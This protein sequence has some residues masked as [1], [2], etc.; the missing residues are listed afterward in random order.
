VRD[1]QIDIFIEVSPGE[2]RAALLDGDSRLCHLYLERA[3][4]PSRQG[5]IFLGRV[6]KVEKGMGAA[7]ID[8][9]SG[10]SAFLGRARTLHEG[11]ALVVQVVRDGWG[12]KVAGVVSRPQVEGRYLAIS[13]DHDDSSK[14]ECDRNIV[15]RSLRMQLEKSVEKFSVVGEK[16]RIRVAAINV[17][18]SELEFEVTQLRKRWHKIQ[19]SAATGSGP[20]VLEPTSSLALRLMRE[21]TKIN[22]IIV[23]DRSVYEDCVRLAA[24]EMP[25]LVGKIVHFRDVS[26]LFRDHGIDEQV[27]EA[28]ERNIKLPS[29]LS[30]TID[31]TEALTAIDVDMGGA[32]VRGRQEEECTRANLIAVPEIA[33]QMILRNLAGLIVIDFISMRNKPNRRRVVDAMRK[34]LHASSDSVVDVLGMTAA[35]LI[36]VTRQR[37]GPALAEFF[38]KRQPPAPSPVALACAALRDV[39]RLRGP[40]HPVLIASPDVIAVLKTTLSLAL[41]KTDRRLGEPLALR[42]VDKPNWFEVIL[43]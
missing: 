37:K 18:S 3:H 42:Q 9:G 14:I 15:G 22:R 27:D 38:T 36:E 30:L 32:S 28:L 33:R 25:D 1:A 39:L 7:F 24:S 12:G 40:G 4:E 8:I 21:I 17:G 20:Q 2:T 5:S 43:E 34:A 16:I 6:L 23:D 41:A 35:G 26:P 11:Q 10:E 19:N 31:Q 29:G 13:A